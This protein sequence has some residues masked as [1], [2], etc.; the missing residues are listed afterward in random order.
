M[1]EHLERKLLS[2]K[3]QLLIREGEWSI[4]VHIHLTK[5]FGGGRTLTHH[6]EKV[7]LEL[8]HKMILKISD[9]RNLY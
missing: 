2:L 8:G 9:W 6:D 4:W 5:K 1:G 7:N 3:D